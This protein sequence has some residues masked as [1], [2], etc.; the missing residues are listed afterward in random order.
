MRF[1]WRFKMSEV[2]SVYHC[3]PSSRRPRYAN[4]RPRFA[5]L[6]RSVLHVLR[7]CRWSQIRKAIVVA[8]T[9]AVIDFVLGPFTRRKRPDSSSGIKLDRAPIPKRDLDLSVSIRFNSPGQEPSPP[10]ITPT[11]FPCLRVI[12]EPFS[13]LF[14]RGQR[15]NSR[16]AHLRAFSCCWR[17]IGQRG[18]RRSSCRQARRASQ[19]DCQPG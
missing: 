16:S 9:V 2:S 3:A 14:D 1:F 4:H 13:K 17:A 7:A 10:S 11:Q 8:F 5:Q 15:I 18:C 12:I 19:Q 6:R